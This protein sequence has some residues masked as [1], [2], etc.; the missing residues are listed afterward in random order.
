M[1][2]SFVLR[3]AQTLG[4]WR[5]LCVAVLLPLAAAAQPTLPALIPQP[6]SIQLTKGQ[7]TITPQTQLALQTPVAEVRQLVQTNLPGLRINDLARP[8]NNITVRLAAVAGL[9]SEGYELVV[10]PTGIR[11]TAP[12]AAG[13]FYGLQTLR[14]LLP[15]D[16][17]RPG[18]RFAGNVPAGSTTLPAC[19]IRDQPRF[20]WRG[21]MLDV[22]RS[23]FTKDYVKR[24]IDLMARYK[25]NVFHWHLTDD[26]G[27]RIEIKSL[28]NLTQAGAWRAPRT[29]PWNSRENPIPGEPQT[30]GGFYTQ[31]EIREVVRY[32]A[33]RQVMVVPEIDMPGHMLAAISAYPSLTC[34]GKK[35]PIY[36]NGKFYKLEDNTLNPCSDST[37]LFVDKVF[38]EVA[39]LFPAPYIHIG[40]D[41][42]YKGFWAS[43]EACK[44]L[45]AANGL[46]TV[47]E[48]QSY[49]VRRVEKIVNSKGKRLIGWDEILEGGLAPGATVMSWRG[50]NG[51]IAAAKQGRPVIMTPYQNCYLDLY[52]GDP[53]AEPSTYSLCRLSNSYAFEPVPD[54]V[55]SELILGGQANLWTESIPTTRH[56][57]YMVWPRAFA[58]AEAL[59]SPKSSRNWTDFIQ[60]MERHFVRFDAAGVNYSRSYL[61]PFVTVQRQG[62]GGLLDVIITHE[63]PDTDLYYTTDNTLPDA[64]SPR[65]MQPFVFPKGADRLR[66]VAYRNGQPVGRMLDIPLTD[67]A[68]RAR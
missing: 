13:I 32:A 65:Y 59:W 5:L 45:M 63:L 19:T 4:G 44:P 42:A 30:Y 54:S 29:G 37:Y 34:S 41:E 18:F 6:Q 64:Q 8:A 67:L 31:D 15:P 53:S 35:V 12:A 56:A 55:R 11:L 10:T 33:E 9:G 16:R 61:N 38:T 47:E 40:G 48:L 62:P 23:F 68:A 60:R 2:S 3:T 57:E 49:F 36:P 1:N 17:E 66:V 7:F 26:Q 24:F 22:S 51:G 25:Y 39:A 27:W 21:M 46:K 43:C 52:Q 28:P 58:I 50:M 20:G 14:Q